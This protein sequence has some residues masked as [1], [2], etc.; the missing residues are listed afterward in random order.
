[1]SELLI[2][3][4]AVNFRHRGRGTAPARQAGPRGQVPATPA[5]HVP[6]LARLMALAL[7]LDGLVQTGAVDDYATLARLGHVSR[8]RITQIVN[9]AHL[10]PDIQEAVL[11]LTR[12][13][14]AAA[15]LTLRALQPLTALLDWG[16]Q[17][18]AWRKLRDRSA[19]PA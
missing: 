4:C 10:A 5:S 9:L 18:R 12:D 19:P 14:V 16:Q 1:M 11:F 8:A 2:L 3:T 7:H 6:R 17:R 15:R 13:Q